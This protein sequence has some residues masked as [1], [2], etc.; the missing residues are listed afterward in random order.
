MAEL[1]PVQTE[2]FSDAPVRVSVGV[3]VNATVADVFKLVAT[4]PSA[5]ARWFVGT[6]A[7]NWTSTPPR[8]V[9]SNR[10]I[11]VWG[12]TFDETVLAWEE[13]SL[14]TFRVNKAAFPTVKA[15]ADE[16]RFDSVD[17]RRTRIRWTIAADAAVP[18]VC[19][20]LFLTAGMT[21]ALRIGARRM[22]RLVSGG[23]GP[24]Q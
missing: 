2:F 16:W 3:V 7:G 8:G 24:T 13:N 14:F 20:R 17:T 10:C 9:G 5:W 12:V 15:F 18:N 4:D 23:A 22:A 1:R 21:I 19:L 6:S 11:R